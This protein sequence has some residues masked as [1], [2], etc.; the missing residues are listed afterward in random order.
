[1]REEFRR[2]DGLIGSFL[3]TRDVELETPVGR[4]RKDGFPFDPDRQDLFLK[5]FSELRS[6]APV[7]RPVALASD[8]ARTNFAFFEAYFSN[9][10]E[11][12]EFE[13]DEAVDIIFNGV[14]PT[15]RPEDAHDI[16]GTYRVISDYQ[17]MARV[18]ADFDAFVSLLTSRHASIMEMR[19]TRQPGVFKDREN[20]AGD[21][22]FVSPDLVIGTL[23]KGFEVYQGL[24]VPLHR[25]VFMMFLVSEVHPFVDGNGRVARVMMNAELLAAG[26]QKIIIPTVFRDNCVAALKALSQTGNATPLVRVS[27]FAQR[28]ALA[29]RWD[30]F[31]VARADL[32]Q[33]HAFLKANEAEERGLR[34]VLPRTGH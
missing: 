18:P 14:I 15:H 26:E 1:M 27:D 25:A 13:V 8:V 10:I 20:R 12:T 9:Y 17:G 16:L 2:L 24:E 5:L 6:S 4:A 32:E 28:Y 21:T 34:L 33:T 29:V 22:V 30:D 31:A 19:P 11:G 23:R 3:G 7:V